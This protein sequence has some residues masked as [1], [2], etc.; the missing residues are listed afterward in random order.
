MN[1]QKTFKS[2]LKTLPLLGILTTGLTLAPTVIYADDNEHNERKYSHNRDKAH[3][4]RNRQ[5]HND[6]A[7]NNRSYSYDKR[8]NRYNHKS[9]HHRNN[10]RGYQSHHQPVYIVND[11]HYSDHYIDLDRLGFMIGLRTGNFDITFHD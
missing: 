1:T 10:W 8:H 9:K 6:H 5:Q 3:H 2:F 7:Y 4:N 11:H